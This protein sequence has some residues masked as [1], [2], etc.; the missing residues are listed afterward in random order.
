MQY[1]KPLAVSALLIGIYSSICL[2][3]SVSGGARQLDAL[4]FENIVSTSSTYTISHRKTLL[5]N[6]VNGVNTLTQSMISDVNTTY[7]IKNDYV[8][9]EIITIPSNC[10]L[11]FKGGSIRGG[12]IIFNNTLI[13]GDYRLSC[14]ISGN[15]ANKKINYKGFEGCDIIELCASIRNCSLYLKGYSFN[16]TK[17]LV[18]NGG[19]RISGGTISTTARIKNE[20]SYANNAFAANRNDLKRELRKD[21]VKGAHSLTLVS[22]EGLTVG[23]WI[24]IG[25]G[26]QSLWAT[27]ETPIAR[28]NW[29]FKDITG[30]DYQI[31]T[32]KGIEGNTIFIDKALEYNY[33]VNTVETGLI[34]EEVLDMAFVSKIGQVK[35]IVFDG[36]TITGDMVFVNCDNITIKNCTIKSSSKR[37]LLLGTCINSKV[38][39][40]KVS[41]EG[42]A[43]A[44]E[45]QTY[46]SVIDGNY[47]ESNG[48]TDACVLTM[49][50]VSKCRI[51]NNT[52]VQNNKS[53]I[54]IYLNTSKDNTVI[55][56]KIYDAYEAIRSGYS[57]GG[58]VI[59]GNAASNCSVYWFNHAR[60]DKAINNTLSNY[61]KSNSVA[62][63]LQISY[64]KNILIDGLKT[65]VDQE[66]SRIVGVV[67]CVIRNC[68]LNTLYVLKPDDSIGFDFNKSKGFD[69]EKSSFKGLLISDGGDAEEGGSQDK[70]F[71]NCSFSS[72]CIVGY[73]SSTRHNRF[74]NCTFTNPGGVALEV[75][76]T[77]NTFRDCVF[78]GSTNDVVQKGK[79]VPSRFNTS[80]VLN[81]FEGS[82]F[83]HG[84]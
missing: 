29:I 23:D 61:R 71:K 3:C 31:A 2:S 36:C 80:A 16:L 76:T 39:N 12:E 79:A 70:V 21:A 75:T 10:K 83:A 17:D 19:T 27:L 55:N 72:K 41:S 60:N 56:N 1:N 62:N 65:D 68:K 28:E 52:I 40:N 34:N 50:G 30:W 81:D 24:K 45:S 22:V 11:K 26:Y 54:G 59:E 47:C 35:D 48:T 38:I 66:Q 51:S 5:K 44:F 15:I 33:P 64:S 14:G 74:Y 58:A 57:F 20:G 25:N 32:I 73:N 69:I 46:N 6:I 82:T 8:L 63:G 77:N 7:V 9:E 13:T 4:S 18:V 84:R 49:L 53:K 37:T 78:R 67:N 42:Y 43:I